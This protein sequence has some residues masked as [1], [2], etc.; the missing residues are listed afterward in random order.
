MK[1]WCSGICSSK[2]FSWTYL[3]E[4][5]MS[6]VPRSGLKPHCSSGITFE[7]I[8]NETIV[9]LKY[10]SDMYQGGYPSR[11]TTLYFCIQR[12]DS[13][14]FILVAK[15]IPSRLELSGYE[16]QMKYDPRLL[17]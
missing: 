6:I 13:H 8:L 1:T 10:L 16:F 7:H 11:I 17:P 15:R 9:R 14:L 4:N 5:I 12:L 3:T 2:H